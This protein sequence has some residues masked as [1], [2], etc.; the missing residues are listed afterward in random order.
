LVQSNY[1][2]QFG[3][4]KFGVLLGAFTAG[5]C[6]MTVNC[7]LLWQWVTFTRASRLEHGEIEAEISLEDMLKSVDERMQQAAKAAEEQ[8]Q[9]LKDDL[10]S[11]VSE[12]SETM[13]PQ[14]RDHVV[15]MAVR[16]LPT[17]VHSLRLRGSHLEAF[18]TRG[19]RLSA[20]PR[21]SCSVG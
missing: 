16:R 7:L 17:H 14:Q 6:F 10:E 19:I 8:T 18:H 20:L 9:A 15:N 3:M 21:A 2:Y 1:E 5:A 12:A 11:A 4:C 13:T